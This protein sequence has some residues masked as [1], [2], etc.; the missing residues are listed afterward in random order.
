MVHRDTG[1]TVG[2]CCFKGPPADDVVEIA[3]GVEPEQQGNG[4]ATEAAEALAN[5][6]FSQ[7][8]R[9]VRVH[10]LPNPNASARFLSKCGFRQV[11]QVIDP[12][13]GLVWHW[14]RHRAQPPE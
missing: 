5:F 14:E 12:E 13:D 3:Y 6:A 11:G 10:T 1:R 2:T 9:T 8:V 4:Y 7:N